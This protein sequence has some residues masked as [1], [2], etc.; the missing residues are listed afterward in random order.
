MSD[1][2]VERMH[3]CGDPNEACD[4]DCADRAYE[5]QERH[6]LR[7]SVERAMRDAHPLMREHIACK[8]I[9][10]SVAVEAIQRERERAE[11]AER[12]RDELRAALERM[13]VAWAFARAALRSG[14]DV[15]LYGKDR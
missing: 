4:S 15:A 9:A 14:G 12:E 5:A 8:A 7:K 3:V 13:A 10:V 11:A 2:R 1:K 6:Q